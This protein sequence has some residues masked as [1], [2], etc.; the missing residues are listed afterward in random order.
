ML[1]Y[2]KAFVKIF[3]DNQKLGLKVVFPMVQSTWR[4]WANIGMNVIVNVEFIP[5]R[6]V[7]SNIRQNGLFDVGHEE[8]EEPEK[9]S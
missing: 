4:V 9:V 1:K 2:C 6:E 3:L 5:D 8:N 7:D